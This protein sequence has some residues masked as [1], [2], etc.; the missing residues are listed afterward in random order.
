MTNPEPT[1]VEQGYDAVYGAWS[2]APTLHRLW[3][4]H[5]TGPDFPDG[6]EHISFATAPELARL[7]QVMH[8]ECGQTIVDLAC[9]AGGSGLWVSHATGARL[10]GVDFSSVGVLRRNAAGSGPSDDGQ[11]QFRHRFLRGNRPG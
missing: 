10:T 7:T 11:G 6:F 5:V 2:H 3:R 4:E 9:G 1:V 8:V